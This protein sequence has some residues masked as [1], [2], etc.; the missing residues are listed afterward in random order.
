MFLY[1]NYKHYDSVKLLFTEVLAFCL[2]IEII[3]YIY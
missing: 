3:L 1:V 2:K